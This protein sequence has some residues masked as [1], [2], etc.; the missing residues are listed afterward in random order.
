MKPK[1]ENY[2]LIHTIRIEDAPEQMTLLYD[3]PGTDRQDPRG[4]HGIIINRKYRSIRHLDDLLRP[5]CIPI[6]IMTVS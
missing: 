4:E 1:R 6:Q 3:A 5:P 2:D